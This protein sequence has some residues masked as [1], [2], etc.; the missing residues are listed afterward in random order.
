MS[1]NKRP[2]EKGPVG[3]LDQ[4]PDEIALKALMRQSQQGDAQSYRQL[5]LRVSEMLTPFVRRSLSGFGLTAGDSHEDVMQ[6]ILMAIHAKRHTFDPNQYFLAWMYAIA[7]YKIVDH[8]RKSQRHLKFTVSFEDELENLEAI[9]MHTIST[10]SEM[11]VATLIESLPPKQREILKLVKLQG[12]SVA[13]T[14]T[15]TGFSP[16]DIKVNVHRALKSLQRKIR[17]ASHEN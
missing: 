15:Q 14:A 7:R 2:E 16:S 17:D 3:T 13:E 4:S 9:T 5:L 8:L 11:D 10:G 1:F 12:L 6:E